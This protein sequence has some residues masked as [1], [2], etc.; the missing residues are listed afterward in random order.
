M[1]KCVE[2]LSDEW[3]LEDVLEE[4][5][6][7]SYSRRS[8]GNSVFTFRQFGNEYSCSE[9]MEKY[10]KSVSQEWMPQSMED[11]K[12]MTLHP[13]FNSICLDRWSLRLASG[14]YRTID[15]KCYQQTGSEDM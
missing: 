6:P 9:E 11:P 1:E 2:A 14:K 8:S 3:V 7:K 15:K 13:V 12:C 10:T 5:A 4:N